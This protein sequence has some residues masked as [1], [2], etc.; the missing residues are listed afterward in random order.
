MP[1]YRQLHL[2]T[3]DSF[4]FN[5]MP[6]DFTRVCWMLLM[7]ILDSEGRGIYNMGW[8]RSKM[9]PIRQD[10]SL[11]DLQKSFD[12]LANRGM[13]NIYSVGERDYFYI[14]K[15]K[16]YQTGTKKEAPSNLPEPLELLRSNSGEAP[17]LVDPAALY[18][19]D[20]C[21]ES[22]IAIV[23]KEYENNI[24][25]LTSG[26]SDKIDADI[27]D[28]SAGWVKDAILEA[29]RQEKRSLAYVEGI[30]KGW[31]LRGR[32]SLKPNNPSKNR[33]SLDNMV[34]DNVEQS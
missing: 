27:N 7:L 22:D 1:K 29:T 15:W 11:G 12:W 21:I 17:E 33:F 31:K 24:G 25:L 26:I 4:D 2:K 18:C 30:L 6:D 8:V 28:Y 9:F 10:I 23:Y 16:N 32:N 34:I 5:E 19:I 13:I 3:L 14:P 20:N